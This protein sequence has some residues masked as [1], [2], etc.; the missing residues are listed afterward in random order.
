MNDDSQPKELDMPRPWHREPFVWMI[1]SLPLS[2]VLA[3]F[4]TLYLAIDSYDGLV[5]DDYYKRGLEI[6]RLL[7]RE[8]QAINMGLGM[9]IHLDANAGNVDIELSA[10][11]ALEFPPSLSGSFTNATKPGLDQSLAFKQQSGG[12]YRAFSHPLQVGRWHLIVGNETW[13]VIKQVTVTAD[14]RVA[15]SE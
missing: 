15:I 1:I 11:Q 14:G 8:Q 5:V 4:V 2:A 13:R 7:D 12:H 3:G 10:Q 6:N 9:V